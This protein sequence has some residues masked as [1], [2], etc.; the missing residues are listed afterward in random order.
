MVTRL[1]SRFL[2]LNPGVTAELGYTN[3]PL[4]MIEDGFDAGVIAGKITD[5]RVVALDAGRIG[6][7]LVATPAFIEARAKIKKPTDLESWP[8]VSLAGHQ[9]GDPQKEELVSGK[10]TSATVRVSPILTSEGVTSLREAVL[11]GTG[12]AVLPDWLV[13]KDLA[14]GSLARVFPQW[15]A[16]DIPA[17]VIYPGERQLPAR[18]RTFIDFAV[19]YMKSELES[20]R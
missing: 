16:Q 4:R 1:I 11:Q 17:H 15:K 19:S 9:F 13:R 7:Y 5:D 10:G 14:D 20:R 12:I 18:V 8:W 2:E 3:R 6:R